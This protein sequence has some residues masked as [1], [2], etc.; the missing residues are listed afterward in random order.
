MEQT[1]SHN[2]SSGAPV[3]TPPTRALVYSEDATKFPKLHPNNLRRLSTISFSEIPS[4]R[5]EV[6]HFIKLGEVVK[7]LT[8]PVQRTTYFLPVDRMNIAASIRVIAERGLSVN[9]LQHSVNE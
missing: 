8:R 9:D 3:G 2:A 6:V 1:V 7:R 5:T 4:E